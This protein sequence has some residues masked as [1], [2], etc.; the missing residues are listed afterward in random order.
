MSFEE[1][2]GR[3]PRTLK[4]GQDQGLSPGNTNGNE[5]TWTSSTNETHVEGPGDQTKTDELRSGSLGNC[6]E[7]KP[8]Q[9]KGESF[10]VELRLTIGVA[11][12]LPEHD[13]RKYHCKSEKRYTLHD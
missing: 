10:F 9:C 8:Q 6:L 11:R 13:L 4:V 12:T 5:K 2:T 7:W 1:M 3:H